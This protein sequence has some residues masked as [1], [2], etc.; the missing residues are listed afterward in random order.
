LEACGSDISL[1]DAVCF[2]GAFGCE[3]GVLPSECDQELC[4]EPAPIC[5]M[6]CES[7]A[8]YDAE[9]SDT[10]WSCGEGVPMDSCSGG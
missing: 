7:D 5:V 1:G 10:G 3:D 6:S 9:C 4:E 2:E 8:E